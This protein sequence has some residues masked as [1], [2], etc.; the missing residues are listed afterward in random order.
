MI[1]IAP[2]GGPA[3][4]RGDAGGEPHPKVIPQRGG[5]PVGAA[6]DVHGLPG[7]RVGEHPVPGRIL[8]GGQGE[9]PLRGQQPITGQVCGGIIDTEGGSGREGQPDLHLRLLELPTRQAI[10]RHIRGDLIQG[11]VIASSLDVTGDGPQALVGQLGAFPVT[12]DLQQPGAVI[13]RV[14]A[15]VAGR[16]LHLGTGRRGNRVSPVHRTPQPV[17]QLPGIPLIYLG[18]QGFL[19]LAGVLIGQ[20]LGAQRHASSPV[21]VDPPLRQ[22][23]QRAGQSGDE[24]AG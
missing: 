8:L 6:P 7:R 3:A 19:D 18:D 11:A 4:P 1:Q 23:F 16:A 14:V 13:E 12:L 17:V 20:H 10:Q 2:V 21:F 5:W 24:G 22:R 15:D 9:R